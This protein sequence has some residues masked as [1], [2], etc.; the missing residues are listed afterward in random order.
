ML[1]DAKLFILKEARQALAAEA[2]GYL[3]SKCM[4]YLK[5]QFLASDME[6]YL[7]MDRVYTGLGAQSRNLYDTSETN[8][9]NQLTS[10]GISAMFDLIGYIEKELVIGTLAKTIQEHPKFFT[11]DDQYGYPKFRFESYY[12]AVAGR[13]DTGT[14]AMLD[15]LISLSNQE[16]LFW[17][18]YSQH[19]N[20]ALQTEFY[21]DLTVQVRV[22]KAVAG[23][24]EHHIVMIVDSVKSLLAST[25]QVPQLPGS[26]AS[27][28][29]TPWFS[30][31][32][33]SLMNSSQQ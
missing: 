11:T 28:P 25:G 12:Q 2:L 31:S 18:E 17:R 26:P 23:K 3:R 5:E 22:P 14:D 15:R 29:E 1:L 30:H 33:D 4:E 10:G 27:V 7:R 32:P 24:F 21:E 8:T 20:R 13:G 19:I 16:Q 9:A 6:F